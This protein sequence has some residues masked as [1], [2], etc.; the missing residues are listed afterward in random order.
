MELQ[1]FVEKNMPDFEKYLRA[2]KVFSTDELALIAA[3]YV[4][5]EKEAD[6]RLK[7]LYFLV[8]YFR[9]VFAKEEYQHPF[10][11]RLMFA[12]AQNQYRLGDYANCVE[13]CLEGIQVT[14]YFRRTVMGG[15]LCELMADAKG[16][17]LKKEFA[18]AE[19]ETSMMGGEREQRIRTIL[20]D[21]ECANA[22]YRYC[23]GY[24]EEHKKE[25]ERKIA[26]WRAMTGQN[27]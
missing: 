16:E 24:K 7:K 27:L 22:L 12:C 10:Y 1:D 2:R 11:A 20:Y 25:L 21:Y 13:Q 17:M 26:Q 14:K 4:L 19:E 15:E 6:E 18:A 3:Y 5:V 8:Y 23:F 9:E